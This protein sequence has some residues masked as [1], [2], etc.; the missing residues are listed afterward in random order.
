[1]TQV[2]V[3]HG[4]ADARLASALVEQL[5]ELRAD[6]RF[7]LSSDH[8]R[9]PAAGTAWQ[10]WIR[11]A[12]TNSDLV[13]LVASESSMSTWCA[14]ELGMARLL[15]KPLLPLSIAPGAPVNPVSAHVQAEPISLSPTVLIDHIDRLTGRSKSTLPIPLDPA[16]EPYPGLQPL[17]EGHASLL[18]GRELELARI[19]S[20]FDPAAA[21]R[22]VIVN[23]PSGSGKSSLIRAGVL[24][25]L[26]QRTWHV[27]GPLQPRQ[28]AVDLQHL[29]SRRGPTVV[30]IDQAEEFELLVEV[31]REVLIGWIIDALQT[32][33]WV[34]LAVRSEFRS[35]VGR[36]LPKPIDH[37]IP[38]VGRGELHD[39]VRGPAKAAN[40]G[41]AESLVD[42]LV[43]E[44]GSGEAL[45][46]LALTLRELWKR[47]DPS[48]DELSN[49]VLDELKGVNGVMTAL[50]Q[51]ALT[52]STEGD[53]TRAHE[54]LALLTRL[55]VPDQLP[56]TR[57]PVRVETLSDTE[58]SWLDL[59]VGNGLVAYRTSYSLDDTL[60][61]GLAPTG[62]HLVDV[63]HEAIFTW[64]PLA[65]AID[66]ERE[67]NQRRSA[68]E[69]AAKQWDRSDRTDDTLLLAGD[70]L[71]HAREDQP[72]AADPLLADFVAASIRKDRDRRRRRLLVAAAIVG[73]VFSLAAAGF[74][75]QQR[76]AATT[77]RDRALVAEADARSAESEAQQARAQAEVSQEET[78]ALQIAA[79]AAAATGTDR[80]FAMLAAVAAYRQS[81]RPQTIDALFQV[82]ATP[83]GPARYYSSVE[84]PQSDRVRWST[85]RYM[86]EGRGLAT[87]HDGRLGV[88][89]LDDQTWGPLGPNTELDNFS[90][91]AASRVP[92]T[93][94]VAFRGRDRA[95]RTVG[96]VYDFR[97]QD[98]H[99]LVHDR[100]VTAVAAGNDWLMVGTF[101][102]MVLAL[103]LDPSGQGP[104]AAQRVGI[105]PSPIT[106][107]DLSV[108]GDVLAVASS[109][110]LRLHRLGPGGWSPGR[111]VHTAGPGRPGLEQ[112]A[113]RRD[114]ETV[115]NELYAVGTNPTVHRFRLLD[116]EAVDVAIVGEHIGTVLALAMHPQRPLLATGGVGGRIQRW[117]LTSGVEVGDALTGHDE[118][119]LGLDWLGEPGGH[120]LL[121]THDELAVGWDLRPARP[122]ERL[123]VI[124]PEWLDVAVSTVITGA[125][126]LA[127]ATVDGTVLVE[128]GTEFPGVPLA[129]RGRWIGDAIALENRDLLRPTEGVSISIVESDRVR[130]LVS[131]VS[132]ADFGDC[133]VVGATGSE[134]V[135]ED[136]GRCG[137]AVSMVELSGRS[138][139][140]P[141]GGVVTALRL[142]PDERL[143]AAAIEPRR[144]V[145]IDLTTGLT[146]GDEIELTE[147][148]IVTGVHWHDEQT[149]VIG[150]DVGGATEIADL[151]TGAISVVD[152]DSDA[153]RFFASDRPG[154]RLF[155]GSEDGRI[156]QLRLTASVRR[157]DGFTARQPRRENDDDAA[158]AGLH[159]DDES[160]V[161]FAVQGRR[162]WAW[163]F[164]ADRLV[165]LGCQRAGRDLT[166]VEAQR[167][168]LD[169]G[170]RVCGPD[171]S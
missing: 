152:T 19:L 25:A 130:E 146:V 54:V 72:K 134:V 107:I 35:S 87:R 56:P 124:P 109:G 139:E 70:R 149:L 58:R 16:V 96:G 101:D 147:S 29:P 6:F 115:G 36:D 91:D 28:M 61:V 104:A 90:V 99:W 24:P 23:G 144:I 92:N 156:I 125:G 132:A 126:P 67:R 48:V 52:A 46:L 27:R 80:D 49:S 69:H 53:P 112:V 110:S 133:L 42:R 13:L 165:E 75:F 103:S 166:D 82:L 102:G 128:D 18:F 32:G 86:D 64:P 131:G 141:L 118:D 116:S 163:E 154:G 45:P 84:A 59:F 170:S 120:A 158:V 100:P 40:L 3:S 39:I 111:E 148:T 94:L 167:L 14:A 7:H 129:W 145:L 10:S 66:R 98:V 22:L 33:A 2:F 4:S 135:V 55:A 164:G 74:A 150:H 114:S 153:I 88:V 162:L 38:Y 9:G 161:L 93:L 50:A 113:F 77:E 44:T 105:H 43:E 1:M 31:E 142:S 63:T 5:A 73:L 119:V 121:S 26:R 137:D 140:G 97:S 65:A 51:R 138:G 83:E 15:N 78:K 57:S 106:S 143:L 127:V 79:E 136:V 89:D 12:I 34:L 41:L 159:F 68:V 155:L 62:G 168:G 123:G 169:R 37:Y 20:D 11:N 60:G 85:L 151:R 71:A 160:S 117:D 30:V 17:T 95:G 47:R 171:G 76:S 122:V 81:P 21:A 108:D 8:E 157:Q